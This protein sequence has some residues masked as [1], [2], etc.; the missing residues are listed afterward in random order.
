MIGIAPLFGAR[1]DMRNVASVTTTTTTKLIGND[2]KCQNEFNKEFSP[3]EKTIQ[4][5]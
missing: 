1:L 4:E 2:D 5:T 3:K